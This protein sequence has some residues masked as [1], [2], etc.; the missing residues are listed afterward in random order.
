MA[1][2]RDGFIRTE[3]TAEQESR[4]GIDLDAV[5]RRLLKNHMVGGNRSIEDIAHSLQMD[6][7]GIRSFL[8]GNSASLELLSRICAVSE[9]RVDEL[10]ALDEQYVEHTQ[11][12]IPRK[13]ILL[14]LLGTVYSE[15][16]I[17]RLQE[18][19][20]LLSKVP[21]CREIVD[22]SYRSLLAECADK[23]YP[24]ERHRAALARIAAHHDRKWNNGGIG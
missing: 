6:P 18:I 16:A 9:F 7:K 19:A 10:F 1:I 14:R 11:I 2:S 5:L 17:E 22:R 15:A 20:V 12:V 24:V 8:R 23:G 3:A 13:Q 4:E 21:S